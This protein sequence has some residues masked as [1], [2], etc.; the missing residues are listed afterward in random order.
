[1]TLRE[2][3]RAA[4]SGDGQLQEALA[5]ST[6][7]M[8]AR[9][10]VTRAELSDPEGLREAARSLRSAAIARLPELLGQVAD[11]VEAAGGRVFFAADAAEATAIHRRRRPRREA[12]GEVEVDG[13]RG[14]RAQ[15]GARGVGVEAVET[16][17]GEWVQQLD[18]E[19]PAHIL[20]PALAQDARG[21]G[22]GA[23]RARAMTAATTPTR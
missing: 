16:D 4:L 13:D 6:D 10:A 22:P 15:R 2:R 18:R 12:R 20:G 3:E 7:A 8:T 1:M 21:L 9:W 11:N 17:L 23:Q 14:D 5:R 19:P